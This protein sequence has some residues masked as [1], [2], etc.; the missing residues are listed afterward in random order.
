MS[1]L[2]KCLFHSSAHF[3]I[4][5]FVELSISFHCWVVINCLNISLKKKNKKLFLLLTFA[6]IWIVSS[7]GLLWIE[8]WR[9][10]VW[11]S[12]CS[13]FFFLFLLPKNIGIEYLVGELSECLILKETSRSLSIEFCHETVYKHWISVRMIWFLIMRLQIRISEIVLR[14]GFYA[15]LVMLVSLSSQR[16]ILW[17]I[18]YAEGC[19]VS[20][21]SLFSEHL[22]RS[23]IKWQVT[24]IAA[25]HFFSALLRCNW[26]VEIVSI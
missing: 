18:R 21:P 26:Q 23:E 19:W 15:S 5:L 24:Q 11:M 9:V 13:T 1:S 25:V 22:Q 3:F 7:L 20:K 2:E 12:L 14:P 17:V 6:S 4:E 8:L 16:K 10:L